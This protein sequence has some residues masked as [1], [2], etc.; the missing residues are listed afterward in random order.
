MGLQ[1]SGPLEPLQPSRGPGASS[2]S[3]SSI[4]SGRTSSNPFSSQSSDSLPPHPHPHP[5]PSRSTSPGPGSA[6]PLVPIASAVPVPLPRPPPYQ[7]RLRSAAPQALLVPVRPHEAAPPLYSSFVTYRPIRVQLQQ[8]G[9]VPR[10]MH[11]WRPFLQALPH[12]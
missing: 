4:S 11:P 7:G 1:C 12:F 3:S 2:G 6:H 9:L 5:H 8:L 10:V